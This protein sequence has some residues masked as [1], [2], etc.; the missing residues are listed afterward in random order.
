[1]ARKVF[2]KGED[3]ILLQSAPKSSTKCS[4][5]VWIRA[6]GAGANDRVRGI[7]IDVKIGSEVNVNADSAHFS[8]HGGCHAISVFGVCGGAN[9]HRRR[10]F[11]EALLLCQTR[12][13]ATFLINADEQSGIPTFQRGF[14]EF[15][16]ECSNLSQR[17]DIAG[18]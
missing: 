10:K 7:V 17:F 11:S 13:A 3:P 18:E 4:Y 6:E 5:H 8:S 12:N 14:L 9:C 15:F 1:M 2:A 16:R